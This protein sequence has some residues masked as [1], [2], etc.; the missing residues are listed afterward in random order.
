MPVRCHSRKGSNKK[1]GY[2]RWGKS[3]KAYTFKKGSKRSQDIAKE[4]AEKQGR[5]IR[6]SGWKGK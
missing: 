1:E 3:G 4:K 2:C 5:A 6:A